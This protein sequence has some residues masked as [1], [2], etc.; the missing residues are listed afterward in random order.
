MFEQDKTAKSA[1]IL[2]SA[3]I[4]SFTLQLVW[5]NTMS[6][7]YSVITF[8]ALTVLGSTY[9]DPKI[10]MRVM[11]DVHIEKDNFHIISRI[12]QYMKCTVEISNT[13]ELFRSHRHTANQRIH[14]LQTLTPN[15][16]KKNVYNSL[17]S[18]SR[19]HK[20]SLSARMFDQNSKLISFV[21]NAYYI[22]AF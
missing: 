5:G 9:W 1:C 8:G 17:T 10:R 14:C 3:L 22:V 20:S 4:Y 15:F 6:G 2:C 21:C 18:T 16:F 12:C 7:K 13:V 11:I 19:S